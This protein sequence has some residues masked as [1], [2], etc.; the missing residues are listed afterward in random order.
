MI[1][2]SVRLHPFGKTTDHTY[3]FSGSIA[4]V[5]GPNEQGKSTLRQAIHH[6]LFTP[7][8]LTPMQTEK[9]VGRWYPRPGGDHAVVTLVFDHNGVERSLVRRWGAGHRS[10]LTGGGP[11][12]ADEA[13]VQKRL[14]EILGH[15]EATGRLVLSTGQTELAR[16]LEAIKKANPGDLPHVSDVL[17]VAA[18]AAGDIG[19]ERLKA[20]LAAVID[21]HFSRWDRRRQAP[22]LDKGSER[23]VGNP[24][25]NGVGTILAAWYA[26]H[27]QGEQLAT[28][29]Q[30][31][32]DLDSAT[33]ELVAL[34]A[35]LA[36]DAAFINVGRPL[37]DGLNERHVLDAA[38]APL[39]AAAAAMT[40]ALG[41]WPVARAAMAASTE[42]IG[43]LSVA[44]GKLEAEQEASRRR[45]D[46][47]QTQEGF[48]VIVQTQEAWNAATD[49]VSRA[50]RPAADV[51]AELVRVTER[52]K[53]VR[54][55]LDAQQLTYTIAATEPV[56]AVV[57][58][59]IEPERVVP[60]GPA[61]A[62]GEARSRLTI[63][64][65]SLT[66]TVTSGAEDVD[67]LF[68]ALRSDE[69]REG[70]LLRACAAASL[71]DAQAQLKHYETLVQAATR[72][73]DTLA[74]QLRGRTFVAWQQDVAAIAALPQTRAPA[75]IALE[76]KD[77]REKLTAATA[78]QAVYG[79]NV[80]NW[81]D[82]Y[83]DQDTLLHALVESR[84]TI[85]HSTEQLETLPTIPAGFATAEVF[86]TELNRREAATT[87]RHDRAMDLVARQQQLKDAVA[88]RCTAELAEEVAIAERAFTRARREGL[89]YERILAALEEIVQAGETD[90]TEVFSAKVTEYFQSV[91]GDSDAI[92]FD[93]QLP[94]AVQRGAVVISPDQL[95]Q[96]GNTAL[97]LAVRLALA[98]IH[99]GS[100]RGFI[101]LDD[102]FVDLDAVRRGRAARL[103]QQFAERHQVVFLTCH[104][105]H[106]EHFTAAGS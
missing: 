40:D 4:V 68:A 45:H 100:S 57:T 71:A 32:R 101:V 106:A 78:A 60:I 95:S 98:D 3:E 5:L 80:R 6:A 94:S 85:K 48:A 44:I 90:P 65:G 9:A 8:Q 79:E 77:A 67:L 13:A 47:G 16:T 50:V 41:K 70:Q 89:A 11:A 7:T 103:V 52:I 43:E 14:G 63:Q 97:A 74:A 29:Q 83:T 28:L 35:Q 19:P 58:A 33:S 99:L 53:D 73:Q 76:L 42:K 92:G 66:L 51:L 62:A 15:N 46:A 86:L 61:T 105:P 22:D 72:A 49:A 25:K 88:E 27:K 55:R 87:G 10:E 96:G 24:W 17:T 12:I 26:W 84:A 82:H 39:Q 1:L 69:Q 30:T 54:N 91:T 104:E 2:K 102:P 31:E 59:G 20:T 75:A 18:G 23:G 37:R 21:K 93:D 64:A 38:L 36:D 81:S 34:E 56:S